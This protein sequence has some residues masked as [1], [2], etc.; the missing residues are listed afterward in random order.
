MSVPPRRQPKML[1]S[2][3]SSS[4]SRA[5]A[6]FPWQE[7]EAKEKEK[8]EKEKVERE[9]R[10]SKKRPKDEFDEDEPTADANPE[11]LGPEFAEHVKNMVSPP[12]PF[13]PPPSE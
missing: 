13:A 2:E 12:T 5:R 7:K 9:T 10:R 1:T 4:P 3:T 6:L 8:R 11:D